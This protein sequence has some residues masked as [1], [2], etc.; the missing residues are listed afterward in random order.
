M[1]AKNLY[2][3]ATKAVTSRGAR[4]GRRTAY[5]R[6]VRRVETDGRYRYAL[7]VR[8]FTAAPPR[9]RRRR[10]TQT[11]RPARAGP[12][13]RAAALGSCPAIAARGPPAAVGA[14]AGGE[15]RVPPPTCPHS[16]RRRR[17]RRRAPSRRVGGGGGRPPAAPARPHVGPLGTAAGGRG[18]SPRPR[19]QGGGALNGLKTGWGGETETD[20][21]WMAAPVFCGVWRRGQ[22]HGSIGGSK[23]L[24]R[25][26]PNPRNAGSVALSTAAPR[27]GWF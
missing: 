5:G 19:A 13:T 6:R 24:I 20:P 3:E 27:R 4:T 16:P 11:H 15:T 22:T 7:T 9:T 10:P 23:R 1:V 26:Q 18:A 21:L 8:G 25:L 14:G 12:R 17:S 2:K